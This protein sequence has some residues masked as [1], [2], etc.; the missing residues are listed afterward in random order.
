MAGHHT[1]A[2]GL[3]EFIECSGLCLCFRH[4]M[5]CIFVVPPGVGQGQ[6]LSSCLSCATSVL[7]FD[8]LLHIQML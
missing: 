2:F 5:C 8:V 1:S 3:L 7:M 6:Y 4:S